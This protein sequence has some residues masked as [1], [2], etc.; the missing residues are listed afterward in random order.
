MQSAYRLAHVCT[1]LRNR[2]G[3]AQVKAALIALG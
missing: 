3:C 1:D 2:D